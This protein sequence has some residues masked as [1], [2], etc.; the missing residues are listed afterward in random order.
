MK[1]ASVSE[2]KNKTSRFLKQ[3]Q[4]DEELTALEKFYEKSNWFE[5]PTEAEKQR[6]QPASEKELEELACKAAKGDKPLSQI[7]I[8]ERGEY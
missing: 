6:Y 3:A 8:E 5:H 7:L 4:K 1:I 2:L